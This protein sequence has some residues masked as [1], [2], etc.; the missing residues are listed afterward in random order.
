[1]RGSFAEN[2]HMM[3]FWMLFC[4]KAHDIF[5]EQML[6]RKHGVQKEYEYI[7]HR[8]WRCSCTNPTCHT[9][10]VSPDLRLQREMCQRTFC[11]IWLLL[12]ASLNSCLFGGVLQFLLNQD[13][14]TDSSLG[15]A[16]WTVLLLLVCVWWFWLDCWYT[17]S[18]DWNRP[19][20][21]LLNRTT[22]PLSH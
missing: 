21:E 7:P 16:D 17:D 22:S 12:L 1:M 8:E 5:L 11:G 19:K 13:T 18:K 3:F 15:S 6:E 9:S 10:L 4:E 20:E 14:T 2:R